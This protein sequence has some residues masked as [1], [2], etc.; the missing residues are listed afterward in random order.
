MTTRGEIQIRHA[1][2][3]DLEA[4]LA[5]E[6]SSFP[7]P[8]HPWSRQQ[9]TAELQQASSRVWL[10]LGPGERAMG[11]SAFRQMADEA[12]L[13]RIATAP[14]AR[15][16]GVAAAL[17]EGALPV[18]ENAGVQRIFLE[19]RRDNA[20]ALALYGRHGFQQVGVRR[21]Y[22]PDGSDALLLARP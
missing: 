17:L 21:R 8:D 1:T 11:Y 7:P 20:P 4:L 12:E 5:L 6:T 3:E 10:A 14:E 19:V 15:R 16:Q 9:L 22:Y 13:L 18:L 2:V